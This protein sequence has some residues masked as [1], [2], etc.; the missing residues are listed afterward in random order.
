MD[1]IKQVLEALNSALTLL[2]S[3]IAKVDEEAKVQN[4]ERFKLDEQK[5]AQTTKAIELNNREAK[6]KDIESIVEFEVQAKKL[7]AEAQTLMK[8]ADERQAKLETGF[9]KLTDDI[10]KANKE[11][12]DEKK[13]NKKQAEALI[14]ERKEFENKVKAYR[15]M[16]SAVK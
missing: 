5:D 14:T 13:A 8:N 12:E 3:K 15:A 1:E 11:I 6:V 4:S 7:M 9:K 10:T 16:A 2:E